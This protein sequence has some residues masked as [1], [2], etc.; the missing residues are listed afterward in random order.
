MVG[1]SL[2]LLC[3]PYE[4]C[5]L[6]ERVSTPSVSNRE[7]TEYGSRPSPGRRVERLFMASSKSI[8]RSTPSTVALNTIVSSL[9]TVQ[10][11]GTG[12]TDLTAEVIKF[13]REVHA[14]EGAATL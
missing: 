4:D 14:R 11:S 3:P 10:T 6:L 9:L 8:S 13:L 7:A 2:A 1:T 12:F 5:G